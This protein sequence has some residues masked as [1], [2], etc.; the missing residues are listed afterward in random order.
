MDRHGSPVAEPGNAIQGTLEA[1]VGMGDAGRK[2]WDMILPQITAAGYL[3]D[4]DLHAFE[5]F[6][7]LHDEVVD[8]EASIAEDGSYNTSD[9][10]TIHQH[11]AVYRRLKILDMIKRYEADFW[12]TPT[13]RAGKQVTQK[14]KT[15]IA[16]R[17]RHG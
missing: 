1:P 2:V 9:S 5:T 8:C 15:G 14:P 6:C 3:T 12:L 11:P 13:A 4:L 17:Q 7:A 16:T 10:G